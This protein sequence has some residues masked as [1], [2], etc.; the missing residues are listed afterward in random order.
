MIDMKRQVE[1]VTKTAFQQGDQIKTLKMTEV[2][3]EKRMKGVKRIALGITLP[4]GALLGERA[5]QW[6]LDILKAHH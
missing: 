2:S 4:G 3:R 6:V 1:S 5:V